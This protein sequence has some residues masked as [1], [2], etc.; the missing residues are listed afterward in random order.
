MRFD[1]VG[2]RIEMIVPDIVQQHCAGDHLSRMTHEIFEQA[3]LAWLQRDFMP[4]RFTTR[5][6]RSSSR[7]ATLKRVSTAV[8][9]GRRASAL[10]RATSSE[11]ANG[12][13]R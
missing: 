4:G 13:T 9:R 8:P 5:F 11:K 12:F 10:T 1:D 6:E 7:S 3:K 2:A